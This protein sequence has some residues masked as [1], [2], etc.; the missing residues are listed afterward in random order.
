MAL[1]DSIGSLL[2]SDQIRALREQAEG[3]FGKARDEVQPA[4]EQARTA[5]GGAVPTLLAYLPQI[6]EYAGLFASV[7]R[8]KE[9]PAPEPTRYEQPRPGVIATVRPYILGAVVLG[10]VGYAA[11]VMARSQRR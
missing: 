4:A 7:F 11:Y 6:L 8:R 9:E 5:V 2:H 3:L 1:K 10:A